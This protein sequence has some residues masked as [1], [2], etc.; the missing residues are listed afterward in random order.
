MLNVLHF[1]KCRE[2]HSS[3]KCLLEESLH[4]FIMIFKNHDVD[5]YHND[6][7]FSHTLP[8]YI[9]GISFIIYGK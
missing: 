2:I 7:F 1:K 9:L 5:I 4:I 8:N 3:I 6:D